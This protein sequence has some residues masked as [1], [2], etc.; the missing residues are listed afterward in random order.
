MQYSTVQVHRLYDSTHV[1]FVGGA[2]Q[3]ALELTKFI[4]VRLARPAAIRGPARPSGTSYGVR[5]T[6]YDTPRPLISYTRVSFRVPCRSALEVV[7]V[8]SY[9]YTAPCAPTAICMRDR[10]INQY[11]S[12][13]A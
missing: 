5:R 7:G 4:S 10:G 6:R 13:R 8:P 11:P 1:L 2:G 9:S 3:P 12:H